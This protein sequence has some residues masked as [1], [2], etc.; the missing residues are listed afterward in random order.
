M[1][2][3]K[4][5]SNVHKPNLLEQIDSIIKSNQPKAI[6]KLSENKWYKELQYM[7]EENEKEGFPSFHEFTDIEM[8]YYYV[9]RPK[10]TDERKNRNLDT[11]KDYIR[12]LLQFYKRINEFSVEIREDVD[13]FQEMSLLKLLRKRHIRRYQDWLKDAPLGRNGNKYSTA[14]LSWKTVVVK[15]FLVWLYK[16]GYI[17]EDLTIDL[18]STNL[19]EWDRPNRELSYEEVFEL[20][21]FYKDH[22]INYALLT[23]LATTGARVAEIANSKFND[24]YYDSYN[25]RYWLKVWG[26][27]DK[28]RELL[29]FNNVFERIMAFRKRRGLSTVLDANDNS[30]LFT[31]NKL[32]AYSPKYLSSYITKIINKTEL[33]FVINRSDSISG[34]AFRH[35][36]AIYSAQNGADIYRIQQTLGHESIQTTRVYLERYMKKENHVALLWDENKF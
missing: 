35:Y 28:P 26:K 16:T 8:I 7:K 21:Q 25:R 2:L 19:R 12:E 9:H 29:I 34:H 3:L 30:P 5:T 10:D 22:T 13:N 31:T 14:T 15:S 36:F 11:K 18:T 23:V 1:S 32:K 4:N 33:P 17:S 6:Q 27:G 24:L 20:L